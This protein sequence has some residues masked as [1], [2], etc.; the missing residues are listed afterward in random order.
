VPVSRQSQSVAL[1]L[2][3]EWRAHVNEPDLARAFTDPGY[4]AGS[5]ARVHVPHHWTSEPAFAGVDGPVLYRREFTLD[6]PPVPDASETRDLPDPERRFL[7]LDGVFYYGDV[8]LDGEYLG[9]TEG[10]FARHAFEITEPVR[11]RRDHVLA[12][13]VA[14]PPQRDRTT[15]RTI[16]GGYWQS[17]VFD[18]SLNPGGIWRPVRV[19]TSGPVRMQHARVACVDASVE[20]ARLA[21]N[22]TLDA[23]TERGGVRLHALVR[24]PDGEVL[25]D[26]WRA[27]TLAAGTNEL[28]W[29]LVVEEPPLWWPRT[30]GPQPLCTF[31]LEVHADG[32]V[33]D[34]Y[35]RRLGFRDVRRHAATFTVNGERLFLKGASYAPA[36]ALPAD[37]DDALLRAD[38]ARAIEAN[39]DLLRVHTHVAPP[40]LYEAADEAGLLLWQ[41]FPMEGGYARGVRKQAAR[42]ARAMVELL[43]HHPSILTW[44]A[45]DAPLGD[46]APAR[47]V[48]N[49]AVPTWGKEVLDRSTA[50][51][52]ARS[53]GTRPVVRSSGA[54][55][56]AHLWFGWRHG[57]I[58][59]MAPAVRALPRLGRFVS[60]FG[61]QSAPVDTGWIVH[62]G[63]PRLDWDD[64]A[65]HRGME[66]P[67]FETYV[68]PADAKSFDEWCDATQAYQAALLQLQIEDLRRCKHR[69]CGG[70]ALFC[71]ADPSPAIGFGLLD[72]TRAPKR[73]FVAVRDAC[74]PV[75]AMVDPRTGHVHVVNDT[76]R[77]I[78]D[79]DVT[80][81]VDGRA[82]RWRGYIESD[83][84]TYVGTAELD[85]AVDVEAVV[86]HADTGRV[87][88]RYP[89]VILEAGRVR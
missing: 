57:T 61:A 44:C 75:L 29:T 19:A 15:K 18:R 73:A 81:L 1:D 24:G 37:A 71:L 56:D 40:G 34:A 59:G 35:S 38:V 25:L 49:A 21:C 33:S 31:D 65:E 70:F 82:R 66:R 46:D 52:I 13:E 20:R 74:R 26:A 55:D 11:D 87:T 32:R 86:E 4:D 39:L 48:A 2:S 16:T 54:T 43:G 42:Q 80:V 68:P 62:D 28:A 85:D 8:W 64:L 89:L 77:P 72:H 9:A 6:H 60:A 41:D 10:Y 45:H 22:V 69:P 76:R 5:W 7:E 23:S 67:A 50:R 63:W 47:I 53:D 88:N 12:V 78:P 30:L 58:A 79:A 27:V 3:G 14:C 51:A 36:R 84:V 83:G 17:P